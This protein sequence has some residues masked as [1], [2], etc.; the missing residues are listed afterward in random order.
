MYALLLLMFGG[1]SVLA[2][3]GADEQAKAELKKLEGTWVVVLWEREGEKRPQ[4][5]TLWVFKAARAD[6]H[7]QTMPINANPKTWTFRAK[8]ENLLYTH[9]LRLDPSQRPK[10]I[11]ENTEYRGSKNLT[12]TMHGIYKIRGDTLTICFAEFYG[13]GKRPN[14]FTAAKGSNRHIWVLKREK[15]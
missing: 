10:A 9:H 7:F 15:R 1:F 14:E 8:P 12:K 3:D 11:D 13:G 5:R 6:V 4:P 2:A